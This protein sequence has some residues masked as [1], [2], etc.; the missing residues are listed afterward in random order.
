VKTSN[1]TSEAGYLKGHGRPVGFHAIIKPLNYVPI[2]FINEK[3]LEAEVQYS[4]LI[5]TQKDN[6]ISVAL[7]PFVRP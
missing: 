5:S 2:F 1:L 3:P 7:K 4:L 6:S